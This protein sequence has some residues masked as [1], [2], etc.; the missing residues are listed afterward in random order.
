M[1]PDRPAA[2]RPGAHGREGHRATGNGG[3]RAVTVAPGETD[4]GELHDELRAVARDLLGSSG[5]DTVPWRTVCGAG[6]PGLE[7]PEEFG[8]A[9]ATFAEAAVVLEEI[10][11]A[12][13]G[14][15]LTTVLA[16][17][18]PALAAVRPEPLRDR[19]FSEVV[20]GGSVPIVVLDG[21][22]VPG[23]EMSHRLVAPGFRLTHGPSG[24]TLHGAAGFV[25]AAPDADL[26]LVPARAEDGRVVLAVLEP[27]APGVRVEAVP[28]VD[29]T[30]ST[31]RVRATDACVR[32]V[33]QPRASG[34][35]LVRLLRARAALA[36]SCDAVGSGSAV[37]DA[38][39]GYA[40]VREQ[41]GRP[42]GSFQAVQHACAD[43][44]VRLTV[45][46][47]LVAVAV[48]AV[49]EATAVVAAAEV[50]AVEMA[51]A[52]LAAAELAVARAK[53]YATSVAVDI[54]GAG[55]QLHGG[56]GYTWESGLHAHLKRATLSRGLFGSPA[57][58]R[59]SIAA[60]YRSR[61]QAP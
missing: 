12:A 36:L 43:M 45:A 37:L 29:G 25:A 28:L 42:I 54:A 50:A 10:G 24:P 33:W 5:G 41:F 48:R 35:L 57:T 60:R 16:L 30:R 18:V 44:L 2:P 20:S 26:L 55:M 46:G 6:W 39:V 15:P 31:G 47:Q 7:A 40:R 32:A 56:Y 4:F 22:Y 1:A 14:T 27:G 58:H 23:P 13:A 53:A 51:A 52:E 19:V 9:G 38:T 49:V 17:T 59:R 11:R 8:G 34:D 61:W 21:E 3:E